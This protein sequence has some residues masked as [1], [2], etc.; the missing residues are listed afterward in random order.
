LY[1]CFVAKERETLGEYLVNK[2]ITTL[3]QLQTAHLEA[4]KTGEALSQVLVRLGMVSEDKIINFY[5]SEHNIP[6]AN[7]EK[8]DPT[9]TD[10]FPESISRR[11]HIIPIKREDNTLTI[12][13][14]DPLN[15]I[16][17]DEIKFRT[18]LEIKSMVAPDSEIMKAIGQHYQIAGSMGEILKSIDLKSVSV[19]DEAELAKLKNIAEEAPVIKLVNYIVE[20]AFRNRASDIHIEPD[21]NILRIRNRVDGILYDIATLPK[22]LQPA[23]ISRAKIMSDLN[24]AVK[25]APQDGRFQY[26]IGGKSIDVRVST[27]PTVYGENVVMRLLDASSVLMGI[28]ELGFEAEDL[29]KFK[30]LLQSPYGI[31]LVTGPT[32]SGKTTTL[33]SALNL[34]NSPKKNI[35]TV[36]D[37]V[38]YHVFGIRQSQIN[39]KAG[40]TFASGLRSILRQDP[41]IIMVGEIRDLETAEIAVQAALTGHLVLSTLHTNDAPSALTRLVD[42]GVKPFLIASS[43]IGIL[44]QRLVRTL[45]PECKETYTPDAETLA[46]I[47]VSLPQKA[48]FYMGKGCK[49]CKDGFRGRSGIHE[50]LVMSERIREMVSNK[51]SADAIRKAAREEGMKTLR[52]NG[53]EKALKG[54]TSL[55]EVLQVTKT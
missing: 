8:L 33:Y 4:E 22:Y 52:E 49:V 29:L 7:L 26:K 24:I 17:I 10:L 40:L 35:L 1:I 25:R 27:F 5:I 41:D 31:I 38:E 21:E 14:S 34:L 48:T 30:Q 20:E 13:M 43:V 3:A 53:I 46:K 6:R 44:A 15:V 12:A 28:D 39:P 42:M 36:E 45:C 23:V 16:V 2:N 9:L 47:D 54:I 19:G 18:G 11:Y 51:S 32:G 55:E 37:P 50:V